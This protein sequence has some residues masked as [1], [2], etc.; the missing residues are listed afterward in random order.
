MKVKTSSILILVLGALAAYTVTAA[1]HEKPLTCKPKP[2]SPDVG[3]RST[4]TFKRT[5]DRDPNRIPPELPMY[6]C[7]CPDKLCKR[8]GD[9]RC[10]EVKETIEVAYT[11]NGTR[12]LRRS[13]ME[14]TVAC[15]CAT[16]RSYMA[17]GKYGRPWNQF[18][19]WKNGGSLN[20]SF[21][22]VPLRS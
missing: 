8:S 18:D 7:A 2:E 12:E 11:V 16:S 1:P 5:V 20:E 4:C 19:T 3:H 13:T 22:S 17:I 6:R 15:V 9:Y 21:L 14:V 10:L